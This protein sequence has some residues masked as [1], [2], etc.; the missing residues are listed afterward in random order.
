MGVLLALVALGFLLGLH[1]LLELD[2]LIC[3]EARIA[4]EVGG[5]AR[6]LITSRAWELS[7]D[8][9]ARR[10]EY[11]RRR[12]ETPGGLI[13]IGLGFNRAF[14]G[15]LGGLARVLI[16]SILSL[17]RVVALFGLYARW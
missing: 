17:F 16:T 12:A 14:G 5:L 13:S 1:A 9:G 11:N 7:E 10:G 4:A 3:L 2:R 8:P 15:L 6:V